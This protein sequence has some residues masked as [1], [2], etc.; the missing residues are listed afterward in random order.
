MYHVISSG[1]AAVILYLICH[2]FYKAGFITLAGHRKIWNTILAVTFL[3]TAVAGLILALKVTYK[4]ESSFFSD[5]LKWHVETGIAFSFTGIIHII[6]HLKYFGDLLKGN[7]N[8]LKD[9]ATPAQQPLRWHPA[10]NLFFIGFLSSSVQILLMREMLNLAGGYE[11]IAGT[12]FASWLISSAAGS[13]YAGRS[14]IND[15]ARINTIFAV[16]PLIS[17]ILLVL[18]NR[19]YLNPGETP[20]FLI[21]IIYTMLVLF[22]FCFASG[23]TFIK[24]LNAAR[25][26]NIY[27]S[28]RSFSI[29]TTGGIAAGIVVTLFSAGIFNT[30]QIYIL[31]VTIFILF[32]AMSFPGK[33]GRAVPAVVTITILIILLSVWTDPDRIV[34]QALLHT[35]KVS[36]S[37]D[38][39]YGNITTGVH[40]D[41]EFLY[42]NHRTL[43]WKYDVTER[44]E[45]VHYAMLQ[46]PSPESV[47][48]ISG[49]PASAIPEIM[50]YSVQRISFVERDPG[51]IKTLVRENIKGIDI[52]ITENADAYQFIK[53]TKDKFDVVIMVLPPPSTLLLNRYYTKDFFEKVRDKL[54]DKGVF[55]CSP[56]SAENYYNYRSASLYSVIYN[57]LSS[58]FGHVLP[59]AGNKLFFLAS[60]GELSTKICSLLREKNIENIYVSSDYLDD[61]LINRKSEEIISI[62][63]KNAGINTIRHPV[64][65]FHYQYYNLTKDLPKVLPAIIMLVIL[66]VLPLFM[67]KPRNFPMYA[68]AAS[69]AGYEILTLVAIQSIAGNI[70]HLTGL[71]LAVLM[72]GLALGSWMKQVFYNKRQVMTVMLLMLAFYLAAAFLFS[73]IISSSGNQGAAVFILLLISLIPS[74]MAGLLFRL[75]AERNGEKPDPTGVYGSDLAGSALGFIAVSGILLPL[76]GTTGTL[77]TLSALILA[78]LIFA[79][80]ANNH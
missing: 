39:P 46:H 62:L 8:F 20:S 6:W 44:E 45:N 15:L 40:G 43:R 4:W 42:Y 30:W 74:F 61:E 7:G 47:L 57:T 50:E 60:D 13:Y 3:M 29:E 25:A 37:D 70:F 41:E 68:A 21:S 64:A 72:T 34:R 53:Q 48:L 76:A 2:F 22:P 35:I 9:S 14:K 31:S 77:M 78:G 23:F 1:I 17:A 58:V 66:F 54:N 67:V 56:G 12:F 52:L 24:V 16:S 59:I 79:V 75:L 26:G 32:V 27:D 55:A 65:C 49:D 38:T 18:I 63:D 80:T 5:L 73:R 69:L 11:L 36:K 33:K 19:L 10:A 71:V 51:L 28:G